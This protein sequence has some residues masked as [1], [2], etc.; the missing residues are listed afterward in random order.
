[1][2]LSLARSPGG[3][4]ALALAALLLLALPVSAQDPEAPRPLTSVPGAPVGSEV[5][6]TM[7]EGLPPDRGVSLGFG[8]LSGGY[9][10]LARPTTGP[11]G[12]LFTGVTVPSWAEPNL[13]YFFFLNLGGGVRIFSDPFIVTGPDGA[14]QVT[15]SVSEADEGCLVMTGLD[16]TRYA[17]NGVTTP[18]PVGVDVVVDGTL[19]FPE[20]LLPERSPCA[21]QPAI[22]V[23]VRSI[24]VG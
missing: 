1:M 22:P 7:T 15:G 17:L 19:G 8:G 10:L 21:A 11:G 14:L 13:V 18:V 16:G 23:R 24:Q 12:A 2:S 5:F 6:V 20:S 9:E 4:P 3:R